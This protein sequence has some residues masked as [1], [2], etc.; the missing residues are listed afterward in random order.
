MHSHILILLTFQ[1]DI[2]LDLELD[3]W[4][5]IEKI[6]LVLYLLEFHL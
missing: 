4:W 2:D 5:M 6:G 3:Q 1:G